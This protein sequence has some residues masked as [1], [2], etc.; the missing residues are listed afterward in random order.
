M[1]CNYVGVYEGL[2]EKAGSARRRAALPAAAIP[3]ALPTLV[4]AE[5]TQAAAWLGQNGVGRPRPR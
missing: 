2:V 3:I 1:A 5:E 4:A